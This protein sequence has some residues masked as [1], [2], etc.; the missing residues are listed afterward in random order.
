MLGP[1][2]IQSLDHLRRERG[3]GS[4]LTVGDRQRLVEVGRLSEVRGDEP[5]PRLRA[6]DPEEARIAHALGGD[7]PDEVFLATSHGTIMHKPP[8][9][10][11]ARVSGRSTQPDTLK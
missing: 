6:Q 8:A 4:Y 10:S 3:L 9:E 1:L 7:R 5:D 11:K 2:E